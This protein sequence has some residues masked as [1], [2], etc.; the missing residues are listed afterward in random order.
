MI[1]AFI[2]LPIFHENLLYIQLS[3]LIEQILTWG[4]PVHLSI[5][6]GIACE[7]ELIFLSCILDHVTMCSSSILMASLKLRANCAV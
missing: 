6:E 3:L 5:L 2:N 7:T 1:L 4:P